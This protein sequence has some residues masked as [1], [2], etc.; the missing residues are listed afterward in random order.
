MVR[1]IGRGVKI[2]TLINLEHK[3]ETSD[4]GEKVRPAA[5]PLEPHVNIKAQRLSRSDVRN[6]IYTNRKANK[7]LKERWIEI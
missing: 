3:L 4:S 2:S 1:V 5:A 6:A 7:D